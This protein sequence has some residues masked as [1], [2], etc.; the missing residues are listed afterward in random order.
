MKVTTQTER[1]VYFF[2]FIECD[3]KLPWGNIWILLSACGPRRSVLVNLHAPLML[4]PTHVE[5]HITFPALFGL[6]CLLRECIAVLQHC[7]LYYPAGK[8]ILILN[9]ARHVNLWAI[10]IFSIQWKI[11]WFYISCI[12]SHRWWGERVPGLQDRHRD[13]RLQGI[14]PALADFHPL[15]HW[16][17]LFPRW[18]RW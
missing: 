8:E 13:T 11:T 12:F 18:R 2:S 17:C 15:L 7:E 16:C 9:T 6:T 5:I 3:N 4:K 1:T 10:L 14:P